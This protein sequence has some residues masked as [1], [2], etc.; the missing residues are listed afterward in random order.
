MAVDD[1]TARRSDRDRLYL[2]RPRGRGERL[3]LQQLHLDEPRNDRGER[4]RKDGDETED[5]RQRLRCAQTLGTHP[6]RSTVVLSCTRRWRA[7]SHT[8]ATIAVSSALHSAA[9]RCAVA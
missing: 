3:A 6:M 7:E 2:I 1:Q 5:A 9:C 4:Q 8:S